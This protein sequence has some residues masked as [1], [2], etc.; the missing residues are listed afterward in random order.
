[1]TADIIWMSTQNRGVYAVVSMDAN[2]QKLR[3]RV[4]EP[5]K[6]CDVVVDLNVSDACQ[7][8][9]NLRGVGQSDAD[10]FADVVEAQLVSMTLLP[11]CA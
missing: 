6:P 5:C 3:M 4:H 9:N 11:R 2:E 8:I 1:M 7:Y 10:R